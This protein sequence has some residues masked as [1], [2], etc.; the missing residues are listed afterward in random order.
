MIKVLVTLLVLFLFDIFLDAESV[1]AHTPHHVIEALEISPVYHITRVL[2]IIVKNQV[3]LKSVDGG[4]SWKKLQKGIDNKQDTLS[5]IAVSPY[6]H[7][8][9]T[10][11][12]IF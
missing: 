12:F 7:H 2:F 6:F 9:S 8:D 4:F 3:L 1:F 5:S 10:C 11:F